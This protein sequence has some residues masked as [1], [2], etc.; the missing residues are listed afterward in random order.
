M[1]RIGMN[2]RAVQ[3]IQ[4]IEISEFDFAERKNQKQA[5]DNADN[6]KTDET[7]VI[8]GESD[9]AKAEHVADAENA[10]G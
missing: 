9:A 1:V 5:T 3:T 10:N 8:A 6:N 2:Q 4:L 7:K